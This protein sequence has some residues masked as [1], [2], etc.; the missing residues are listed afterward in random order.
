MS[1]INE[2]FLFE[3]FL[4]LLG[5]IKVFHW[6]TM[7]YAK[8]KALDDLH[9]SLSNEI[10]DL[11]EVYIGKYEKQPIEKF[12]ISMNATSDTSE[13]II[14]LQEQREFIRGIR[15]KNFKSCS[16]IQTIFDNILS[17]ISKT[18]YLCKLE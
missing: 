17:V 4:G 11:M 13:L 15:N 3:Y 10:D 14:Y 8:H 12:N 7:N 2:K 18:I 5:Q 16:E 1:S 9:S 6:T